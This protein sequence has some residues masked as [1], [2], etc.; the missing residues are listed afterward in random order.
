VHGVHLAQGASNI[1]TV[2]KSKHPCV[3]TAVSYGWEVALGQIIP[4]HFMCSFESKAQL[5]RQ[6]TYQVITYL[7]SSVVSNVIISGNLSVESS[8]TAIS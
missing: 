5:S 6:A 7:S 2:T 1:M 8:K 3:R 4:D